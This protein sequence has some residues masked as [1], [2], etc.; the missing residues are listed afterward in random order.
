[1]EGAVDG[2]E[3]GAFA[4]LALGGLRHLLE[5]GLQL[6]DA[7]ARDGGDGDD[8][9]VLEE[10]PR[11][12]RARV[13]Y[14]HLEHLFVNEVY[15]VDYREAGLD[16]EQREYR[17]VFARLRHYAVVGRYDEHDRVDARGSSD[18]LADEFLVSRHVDDA[19]RLSRRQREWREAELDGHAA[20]LFLGEAVA[21]DAGQT[22][23]ERRLAVVD[24][25]RRAYYERV[26]GE[27]HFIF[28]F[29]VRAAVCPRAPQVSI[30]RRRGARCACG[31]APCPRPRRL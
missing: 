30:F 26:F 27:S 12:Q 6:V 11:E 5:C 21:V 22:L 25:S 15:L 2:E 1:M 23:D 17:E 16:A 28:S 8:G 18:H 20:L 19:D 10:G 24:V 9:L 4:A 31:R 13:V 7:R 29:R 14:R 3:E